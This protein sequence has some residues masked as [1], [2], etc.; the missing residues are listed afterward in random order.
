MSV[1]ERIMWYLHGL[2]GNPKLRQDCTKDKEGRDWTSFDALVSHALRTQNTYLA[3]RPLR[4]NALRVRG[5]HIAAVVPP[6]QS[7]KRKHKKPRN[8]GAGASGS[9]AVNA[10]AAAPPVDVNRASCTAHHLCNYCH[11]PWS[12]THKVLHP[13]GGFKCPGV[14]FDPTTCPCP[15]CRAAGKRP[16]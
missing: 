11:K 10:V 12:P 14:R 1:S 9:G 16:M 13:Q 5:P 6:K 2:Q 8:S 15:V 7:L 3:S 4:D